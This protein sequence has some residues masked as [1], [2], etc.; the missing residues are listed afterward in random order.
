MK[1]RT[2]AVRESLN[3]LLNHI[4]ELR[5]IAADLRGLAVPTDMLALAVNQL[6]VYRIAIIALDERFKL[7]EPKP[8]ENALSLGDDGFPA[9]LP[10][11]PHGRLE[12]PPCIACGAPESVCECDPIAIQSADAEAHGAFGHDGSTATRRQS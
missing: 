6:N 1:Q 10:R 9:D 5:D 12:D 8:F 2:Q 7:G 4:E 11:D 3:H